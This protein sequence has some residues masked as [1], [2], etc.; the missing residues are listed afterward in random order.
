MTK[1]K[2]WNEFDKRLIAIHIVNTTPSYNLSSA[3]SGPGKLITLVSVAVMIV[4]SVVLWYVEK[5]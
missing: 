1:R 3:S 5:Y 4:A 2:A